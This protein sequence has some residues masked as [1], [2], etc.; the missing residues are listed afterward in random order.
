[1]SAR[2]TKQLLKAAM[3]DDVPAK[4]TPKGTAKA[5]A[6]VKVVKPASKKQLRQFLEEAKVERTKNDN[7]EKNL[8]VLKRMTEPKVQS[9]MEKI[10]QAGLK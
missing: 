10:L 4:K 6:R 3:P 5:K 8:R 1:M 7:T 2:I 9:V